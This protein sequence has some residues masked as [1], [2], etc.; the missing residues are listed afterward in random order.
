MLEKQIFAKLKDAIIKE[1]QRITGLALVDTP[2]FSFTRIITKI[3]N[4]AKINKL[5]KC[6][7]CGFCL[8]VPFTKYAVDRNKT[9]LIK[10]IN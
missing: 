5:W 4:S 1:D 7:E 6:S 9:R 2:S 3:K 10:Y 8:W